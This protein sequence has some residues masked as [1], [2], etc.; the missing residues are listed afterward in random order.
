V[1]VKPR[2]ADRFSQKPPEKILAVLV[3]GPDQ[4]LVRERAEALTK[5][6]VPDLHDPFRVA[7]FND[8]TIAADPARLWDE[9]AAI[10][11][12]GGRRVV[13]VRGAGNAVSKHFERYLEEPSGDALIVV[14]AGELAKGASLRRTFE[15]A[16]NA[17][18][19]ACYL[20]DAGKLDDVV[21]AALKAEGLSIVRA[22]LGDLVSRLGSDRGVT[23]RELEKLALYVGD[24]GPVTAEHVH[25]AMGDESDLR[26]DECCDAAGG[27]DFKSLDTA[28]ARLWLAGTSPVGILRLALGHF[29]RLTLVRSEYDGGVDVNSAMRKLRPPVHF[30]RADAFKGQVMR[31]TEARL[32]EA[33]SILYEAEALTKTTGVPAEAACGRALFSV[34]ALARARAN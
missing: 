32:E 23:R 20:D 18:V 5:S 7:E 9:A 29:Q 22:A 4:G 8:D 21:R 33:L 15:E 28:L 26:M 31:W 19:I 1:I 11:M 2:E 13:R 14:E 17:A 27:G 30:S 12:L 3:Y 16:D 6:V 10:S 25:N 34:A 24:D